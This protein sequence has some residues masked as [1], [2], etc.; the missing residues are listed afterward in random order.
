M[1][2]PPD[3]TVTLLEAVPAPVAVHG[4]AEQNQTCAAKLEALKNPLP[5]TVIVVHR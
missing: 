2:V 4:L 5:L 3:F 1:M